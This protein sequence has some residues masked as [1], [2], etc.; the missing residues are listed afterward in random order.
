L[1]FAQLPGPPSLSHL[2]ITCII[3]SR[4]LS[5]GKGK[6]GKG[7]SSKPSTSTSTTTTTTKDAPVIVDYISKARFSLKK[8]AS[9]DELYGYGLVVSGPAHRPSLTTPC[10]FLSGESFFGMKAS[11]KVVHSALKEE[12]KFFLPMYIHPTHGNEIK[13]FFFHGVLFRLL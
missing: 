10:E 13:V 8:P 4:V 7:A 1:K 12:L 11:M 6:A 9:R 5:P 2:L 3:K